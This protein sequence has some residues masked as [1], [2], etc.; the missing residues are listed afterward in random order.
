MALP[1]NAE[2]E[3]KL[4][5][6]QSQVAAMPN[7][8]ESS[9][10]TTGTASPEA[11]DS[12]DN[13]AELRALLD[14]IRA[15]YETEGFH[16]IQAL[17]NSELSRGLIMQIEEFPFLLLDDIGNHGVGIYFTEDLDDAS[18][19]FYIGSF[20]DGLRSGYGAWFRVT[21]GRG[22][23]GEWANDK[24]NGVGVDSLAFSPAITTRPYATHTGMLV[25]GLWNGTVVFESG[26][27]VIHF[28][29]IHGRVVVRGEGQV[30][31]GRTWIPVGV[32]QGAGGGLLSWSAEDV[33]RLHGVMP[34]EDRNLVFVHRP[35]GSSGS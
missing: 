28:E 13:L 4:S 25:D 5:G 24:P 27:N 7:R 12:L 3:A 9:Q 11:A 33:D 2:I 8:H 19:W 26:A 21:G 17:T 29:F 20:I 35:T 34:Y 1:G 32:H 10:R 18:Y 31:D 6:L 15:H 23:E 22:Y 14:S 30:R 16:G